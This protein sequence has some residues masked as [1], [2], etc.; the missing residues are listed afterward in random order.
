MFDLPPGL[1]QPGDAMALVA[2]RVW[3]PPIQRTLVEGLSR[4]LR[5]VR[6]EIAPAEI[7][8]EREKRAI[9]DHRFGYS[10]GMLLVVLEALFGFTLIA[11]WRTVRGAPVLRNFGWFVA[12][13]GLLFGWALW[14]SLA[15]FD[16]PLLWYG[17]ILRLCNAGFGV[18]LT[19]F[20]R[21]RIRNPHALDHP[22]HAI[23]AGRRVPL[24]VL[25]GILRERAAVPEYGRD[26]CCPGR[27]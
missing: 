15:S 20:F 10:L 16:L 22:H 6:F 2:W 27:S 21:P 19:G 4:P 11:L 3:V 9:A 5:Q 24:L 17:A 25:A 7:A 12:A 18:S 26:H 1:V 23:H 8:R 13:T 14:P